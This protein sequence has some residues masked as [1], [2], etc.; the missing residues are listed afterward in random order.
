MSNTPPP[1]PS[2]LRVTVFIDGQNFYNDCRKT[3]GKGEAYPHLLGQELCGAK[4]G[5]DRQLQQ[6]RFYTGIHSPDRNPRM[7]A[8]M[9][10]R[11]AMMRNAGVWTFSRPLKYS[12]EWVRNLEDG[13]ECIEIMKG[14]EKGIDV[15]LA[16]DLVMLATENEYDVAVVLSTDTD[17][18]EAIKDVLELRSRM[19]RWLAVENA[20]CIPATDSRTG[21]R[22]PYKRLRS[23]GRLL[24]ID[25]ELFNR[26]RDDAKYWS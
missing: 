19:H 16:L 6:V 12:K 17:L 15:R 11:L 26:I 25:A 4:F 23:A 20:I 18:D 9:T 13:D 24:H 14:R 21:R 1:K 3:F 7:H 8:Y 22:P 5:A 10:R 2:P